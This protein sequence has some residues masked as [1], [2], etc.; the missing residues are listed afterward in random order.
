MKT[1]GKQK[2]GRIT[3]DVEIANNRDVENSLSG[4]LDPALVRRKTIRAVVDSGATRLVL[5]EALVKE[6]AS[7]A[8]SRRRLQ[9]GRRAEA[10]NC[11]DRGHRSRRSGFPRGLHQTTPRAARSGLCRERN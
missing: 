4:H 8:R 11:P 3:V 7:P 5:P 9:C 2:M 6:L 10:R 1:Q